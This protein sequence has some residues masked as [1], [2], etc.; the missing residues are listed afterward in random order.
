MFSQVELA[1]KH[2]N[3]YGMKMHLPASPFKSTINEK[4]GLSFF[5][6]KLLKLLIT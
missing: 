6:F 2:L 1:E 5:I 3:L 4:I